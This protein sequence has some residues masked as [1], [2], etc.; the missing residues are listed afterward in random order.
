MR[1]DVFVGALALLCA[2]PAMASDPPYADADEALAA[3]ESVIGCDAERSD[4]MRIGGAASGIGGDVQPALAAWRQV[5]SG[6]SF[7]VEYALPAP[8]EVAGHRTDRVLFAAGSVLA[9]LDGDHV[10]PLSKSLGLSANAA[11]MAGHI[12]TRDV[13]S[14]DLGDGVSVKV[15]QTVSTIN[16]HP[17]RT[18]LGCEYRLAY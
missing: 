14:T 1:I 5:E 17:G 18:L 13:R 4:Y 3:L 12:R 15:V 16:S 7:V 2:T 11:A 6:N 9:V 8:I 10:E